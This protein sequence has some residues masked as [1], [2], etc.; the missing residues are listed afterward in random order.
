MFTFSY[1]HRKTVICQSLAVVTILI[2]QF[3]LSP[4]PVHAGEYEQFI[5]RYLNS[6]K[7]CRS[8]INLTPESGTRCI[9]DIG[10]NHLLEKGVD[11]ANKQGKKAFGKEFQVVSQLNWSSVSGEAEVTGDLDV[12][13][14]LSFSGGQFKSGRF[15]SVFQQQGVT[16]FRD[17]SGS[18]RNNFRHGVAYR[19][20]L[21]DAADSDI[22]GLSSFLLHDA[23]HQHKVVVL[24]LDY[25]GR[26]GTGALRYFRPQTG[27]QYGIS[28]LE[29]RALEGIEIGM[30]IN[31]TSAI[32][33]DTTM[34]R[35]EAD[36][37]SGRWDNGSRLELGWRP[38]TWLKLVAGYDKSRER[39][40]NREFRMEVEIPLGGPSGLPR[41]RWV[42]LGNRL[43]RDGTTESDLWRPVKGIGRIKFATRTN[44]PRQG[45]D[46]EIN[47]RFLEPDVDSGQ[48]V[49]V[50]VFVKSPA[51]SDIAVIVRLEPGNGINPAVAGEDFV[52]QP[53]HTTIRQGTTNT[54]VSIPLIRNDDMEAP[55]S[56][57]VTAYV[58]S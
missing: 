46:Q 3:I 38:H 39:K 43:V 25:A 44:T 5:E 24:G 21:S 57:G 14:P 29:Q 48:A 16:R 23:E 40:A 22:V 8:A 12:V 49:R 55:R 18:L 30:R 28:G 7:S 42:G 27:W 13:A 11:L 32:D 34:Y 35:W 9:A 10:V 6:V 33:L 31:L 37:D 53:V 58:A 15:S 51:S 41:P 20:R 47:V 1:R 17:T 36:D 56:L 45:A 19:F 50:E 54:V 52:D 2:T 4:S 26:W